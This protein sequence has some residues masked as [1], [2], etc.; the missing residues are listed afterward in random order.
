MN[1][2]TLKQGLID[3]T[4]EVD[5]DIPAS[6]GSATLSVAVAARAQHT[7]EIEQGHGYRACPYPSGRPH[8]MQVCPGE[9]GVTREQCVEL[10]K[11]GAKWIGS[12]IHNPMPH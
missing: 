10:M 7:E 11:L 9:V 6:P 5:L 4:F 8:D 1:F 3:M 2:A 12:K